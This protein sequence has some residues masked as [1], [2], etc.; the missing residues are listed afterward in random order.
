MPT[1]HLVNRS[2]ADGDA[3]AACLRAAAPD[4]TLLLLED[5]V[6]GALAGAA[7]AEPGA[8]PRWC[9]LA[10]D[11]RARGIQDRLHASVETVDHGG[12][13]ALAVAHARVVSWS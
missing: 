12:F 5:G 3:L 11:A 10:P 2:P 8:G 1:L 9:V 6:Y 13:V 7:G 4:D